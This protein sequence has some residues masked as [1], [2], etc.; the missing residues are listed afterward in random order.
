MS[1]KQIRDRQRLAHL[2]TGALLVVYVYLPGVPSPVFQTAIRW[3]ILPGMVLAGVL[4]W[5]WPKIRRR[6]R[7]R[8]THTE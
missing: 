6:M 1:G 7:G 2:V 8:V 4:M 3:V 5:Q